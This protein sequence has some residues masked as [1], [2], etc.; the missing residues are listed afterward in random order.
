[1]MSLVA[2]L[3]SYPIYAT[4]TLDNID[5]TGS[6]IHSATINNL[7]F[8]IADFSLQTTK[9]GVVTTLSQGGFEFDRGYDDGFVGP[10]GDFQSQS[11][12]TC[13]KPEIRVTSLADFA[14]FPDQENP[15]PVFGVA[16][17]QKHKVSDKNSELTRIGLRLYQ[18]K[19]VMN[20]SG[21]KNTEQDSASTL[22]AI[23]K[24]F[25]QPSFVLERKNGL[26]VLYVESDVDAASIQLA[27]ENALNP[28]KKNNLLNMTPSTVLYGV[29]LDA[30]LNSDINLDIKGAALEFYIGNEYLIF[31]KYAETGKF[32][33]RVNRVLE[34]CDS[35][36]P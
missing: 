9:A 2:G 17:F 28:Q 10:A 36:A 4:P 15:F 5:L 3:A 33:A 20:F 23:T 26:R 21:L 7:R 16:S 18:D 19:S 34:Q 27:Y 8:D 6:T 11:I 1:M 24:Q 14:A 31:T 32:I 35:V 13:S 30:S 25:G 29:L 22:A 12:I